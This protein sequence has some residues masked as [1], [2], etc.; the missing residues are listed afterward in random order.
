MR[1]KQQKIRVALEHAFT[2][3]L[4]CNHVLQ[5]AGEN[6]ELNFSAAHQNFKDLFNDFCAVLQESVDKSTISNRTTEIEEMEV[7]RMLLTRLKWHT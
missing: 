7:H 1:N 4:R 2:G 5:E 3:V 6:Q